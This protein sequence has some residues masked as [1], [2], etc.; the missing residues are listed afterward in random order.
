MIHQILTAIIVFLCYLSE[1]I[2][3]CWFLNLLKFF[4]TIPFISNFLI[5]MLWST[6]SND[7]GRSVNTPK[8]KIFWSKLLCIWSTSY[9]I[10]WSIE[11]PSCR[12]NCFLQRMFE[13]SKC[14]YKLLYIIRSRILEKQGS[15]DIDL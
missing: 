13:L 9:R 10:A 3:F 4:S 11:F 1:Y 15:A 5:S 2:S 12:P 14:S 8:V 6:K 7:L